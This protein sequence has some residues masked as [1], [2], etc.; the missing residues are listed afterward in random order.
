MMRPNRKPGAIWT[1]RGIGQANN[2]FVRTKE[3]DMVEIVFED[4]NG[5]ATVMLTRKD[6]RL[7]AKRVNQCLDGSRKVVK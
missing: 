2:C 3:N 5:I 6:A 4:L 7:L 1:L